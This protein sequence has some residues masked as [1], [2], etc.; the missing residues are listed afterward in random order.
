MMLSRK[1]GFSIKDYWRMFVA[2]GIR[3]PIYYFLQSHLFDL[4]YK[5]DTHTWLPKENYEEVP[6]N[7]EHGV[8]YMCSWTSEVKR[9]FKIVQTILGNEF[10]D[11]TFLDIGCGK[12][13]VAIIWNCECRKRGVKQS[14]YGIDYYKSFIKIA[15]QN[16]Q[17][18]FN[19]QG[20]YLHLDATQI[21]QSDFGER[22]IVYLYNPFD[23]IILG[24]VLDNLIMLK[25]IIIYNNPVHSNLLL[26]KGWNVVHQHSGF[27]PNQHTIIYQNNCF[28]KSST[29]GKRNN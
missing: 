13:K 27:H 26:E 28:G 29:A 15:Q 14:I 20:N 23:E 1:S 24:K 17:R 4:I 11:Y 22:L 18:I 6:K 25:T 5:T 9:I 10:S 12:G 21:N 16:H 2:R 3:L 8:L 19:E 7:F